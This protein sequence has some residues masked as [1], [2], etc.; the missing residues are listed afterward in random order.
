M[1]RGAGSGIALLL[2]LACLVFPAEAQRSNDI[3]AL[4]RE[5]QR[6][7]LEN[8]Y[9]EMER[10][11][12][13]IVDLTGKAL[14]ADHPNY[15]Y[16]LVTLST[17]TFLNGKA[18][19]TEQ[20]LKQA[21]AIYERAGARYNLE[22]ADTLRRLA[23]YY[24]ES[25]A[26][27]AEAEPLLR[28][29]LSIAETFGP[30][31]RAVSTYLNELATY[32][33]E[34]K[35]HGDADALYERSLQIAQK[36]FRPNDVALT[37]YLNNLAVSY[38]EQDR[39]PEAEALFRRQMTIYENLRGIDADQGKL[40]TAMNLGR[41]YQKQRRYREAEYAMQF[42]AQIV[43]RDRSSAGSFN[44]GEIS[45]ALGDIYFEQGRDEEA[46]AALNQALNIFQKRS[47]DGTAVANALQA[48]GNLNLKLGR[49]AEAERSFLRVLAIR[50]P[51]AGPGHQQ[52][53]DMLNGLATSYRHQG[54]LTEALPLLQRTIAVEKSQASVALPILFEAY[55]GK[56]LS[57][58]EAIDQSLVVIQQSSQNAAA[59]AVNKL[60]VRLAAGS[61][62]LAL[63]V[64][65]D[66]DL[67]AEEQM[68]DKSIVATAAKA[69]SERDRVGEQRTRDRI[70]AIA[71]E[72]IALQ[73]V[74][75]TEFP[76]YSALSNPLP[77]SV[78]EI[79]PLLSMDEALVV[80]TP[81]S[82][83]DSY[84]IA[85]S[86]DKTDWQRI[87][88]GSDALTQ[89][90]TAFR[91]PLDVDLASEAIGS[92]TTAD[93]FN[94]ALAH[95]LYAIL[96]G[97]VDAL[98]RDKKHLLVVTS[99]ALTALPFHSLV[100]ERPVVAQPADVAAYRE[101]AWLMKRQAVT[102]IPSVASLKALRSHS[103]VTPASK[104][105]SGFGDPVFRQTTAGDVRAVQRKSKARSVTTRSF[106]DFW[107][108]AGIDRDKLLLSQLPDTA[109]E[110]RT[111]ARSLGVPASEIHLGAEATE[112]K[113][114]SLPLD[115]YRIVYFAT[116]GLV[117]GD[118]KGFAEPSLALS[119]PKQASAVD[120]GLL[121]ASEIAELKLNADWV[122]LS[123][124]NTVA[125][126][127]PGAEALSGLA[128][129]FFY[130][131]AR[132]LLVSHWAVD[133]AAATRLATMT[134]DKIKDNLKIGRSEA[135]RQA[136]LDYINDASDPKHAYP[137]YWAPFVVVGEGAAR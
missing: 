47:P 96:F 124:C 99:G 25:W 53:I 97:P 38:Y 27:P 119:T 41:L 23:K 86:R 113:V 13:Q 54:R 102:V 16:Q 71:Q 33:S 95:E 92:G 83:T 14:G 94:L 122:V 67:I 59:A 131:G 30:E 110:L 11:Q 130:A 79:Q 61:D 46:E 66:Q 68:L 76:D 12:R 129:A 64:R 40:D 31:H 6:L 121:T 37:K 80:I 78:K 60:A 133:S 28:R 107:K 73:R 123:A 87:A 136:M 137:A 65:K 109:D 112:T 36:M 51:R 118:I 29:S 42:A 103:S 132:A 91:R 15:G 81:A 17:T 1:F 8:R 125:G 50:E 5:L 116:H 19:E 4:N 114:K 75:A 104:P 128:R 34:Q 20:L 58:Q 115:G 77:T 108:G 3:A 44:Q 135:L 45:F 101:A 105:M 85:I 89:R 100:T 39:F 9:T 22:I 55:A 127:K 82:S 62:R 74:F 56:L 48:I 7:T 69:A 117:A 111:V 43:Q 2:T 70:A 24:H 18:Q 10:V 126:D 84:V 35:R 134:F 106:A 49:H 52:V 93:L 72:R 26:R 32:Y 21:L 98:I 63:L 88:L 120:D 90:V 57:R